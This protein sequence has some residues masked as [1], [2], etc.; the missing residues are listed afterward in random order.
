MKRLLACVLLCIGASVCATGGILGFTDASQFT[1]DTVDWC[2][3]FAC[4]GSQYATPQTWISNGTA[5]TGL[6]GLNDTSEGFYSLQQGTTWG[7]DFTTGMGLIYNGANFGNT[8]T[9]IA[10]A[11]DQAQYGVGAW[12]QT[13]FYGAFTATITLY[14]AFYQTIG[15]FTTSGVASNVPGTALFIGAWNAGQGVYAATFTA[16][17]SGPYEPDFAIGSLGFAGSTVVGGIPEPASLLLIGPAL[18]ALAL[19][20]RRRRG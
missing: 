5:D 16:T 18:G 12:I 20:R 2:A 3:N 1:A 8:P 11:F 6:V 7:G 15:S 13:D 17:G 19:L 10:L 9:D 4:D 14:D